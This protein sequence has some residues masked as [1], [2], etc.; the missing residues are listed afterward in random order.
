MT[1]NRLKLNAKKT[2]FIWL[3]LSYYTESVI[4]LPLSVG[5][6]TVFRDDTV[7]NLGVMFDA[8][9]TTRNHVDN[10]VRSCFFQLH[11][12]G[13]VRQSV[14][15]EVLHALVH[16]FITSRYCN[17]LLYCVAYGVL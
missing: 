13:S 12:I 10:V 4:R 17:A 7:L 14:T 6:S 3:G 11:Q 5:G 15:D 9:L 8:Q 16:T 1:S 2:Q